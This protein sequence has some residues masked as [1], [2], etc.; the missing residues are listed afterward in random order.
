VPRDRALSELRLL[1]EP[2]RVRATEPIAAKMAA[3][4]MTHFK[5]FM[6]F[7]FLPRWANSS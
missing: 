7:P 5:L 3:T 2:L 1:N 4:K 6:S